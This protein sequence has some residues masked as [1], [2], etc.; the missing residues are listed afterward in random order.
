MRSVGGALEKIYLPAHPAILGCANRLGTDLPGQIYLQGAIDGHHMV[1]LTNVL[2]IVGVTDR[3]QL[4][5]G[6]IIQKVHQ[7]TRP[8]DK[9]G[10]YL[11]SVKGFAGPG[12]D[13]PLDEVEHPIGEHFAMD[14]QVTPIG[15]CLKDG[16]RNGA[17]TKLQRRP[18]LDQIRYM[19]AYLPLHLV[20]RL[21]PHLMQ[22]PIPVHRVIKLG[23]MHEAIAVGPGY[24][25][26]HEGDDLAGIIDRLTCR[27][28]GRAEGAIAMLVRGRDLN[29]R[30]ID[31]PGSAWHEEFGNS[32][33]KRRRI[34]GTT[35][36]D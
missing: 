32:G 21:L 6:I 27:I 1:K 23:Q 20:G 18:I 19:P 12:N 33:Q 26:I 24:L 4:N 11:A 7:A 30:H 36:V 16:V 13:S 3:T 35:G 14:A 22:G 28:D 9:A 8:Y 10:D 5:H 29:E 34:T 31:G 15:Q 2:D 25:R 17:D